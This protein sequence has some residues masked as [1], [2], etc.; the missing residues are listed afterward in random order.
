MTRGNAYRGDMKTDQVLWRIEPMTA[1]D[2]QDVSRVER[3]CFTNPWPMSAYRRELAN[4]GQNSYVVLREYVA[5]EVDDHPAAP[6]SS[7]R[8]LGRGPL[9]HLGFRSGHGGGIIGFAG[10]WHMFEEA[11]ITTIGVEPGHR[12]K[13]LGEF[14]L[15]ALVDEALRRGATWLTLEVRVSNETAQNLYRKYGFTVQGTRKRYYSDNNEDAWIMWSPSL[16]DPETLRMVARHR[17]AISRHLALPG[18]VP[19]AL[20]DPAL[21][22]DESS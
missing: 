21:L 10:M 14:L 13:G 15:M 17:A 11:H 6:A 16:K 3:R 22:R 12:G 9:R 2:I 7:W 19:E 18:P 5:D 20:L 4:P 8:T 1:D